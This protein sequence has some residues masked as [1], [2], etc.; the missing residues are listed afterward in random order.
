VQAGIRGLPQAGDSVGVDKGQQAQ[1]CVGVCCRRIG[2][3]LGRHYMPRQRGRGSI[4]RRDRAAHAR[5]M[6][7]SATRAALRVTCGHPSKYR[8]SSLCERRPAPY[9]VGREGVVVRGGEL[10]DDLAQQLRAWRRRTNGPGARQP[11]TDTVARCWRTAA[12][13]DLVGQVS[14]EEGELGHAALG[15]PRAQVGPLVDLAGLGAL[16]VN[17]LPH[18]PSDVQHADEA[19]VRGRGGAAGVE[20][21]V[22]RRHGV[23]LQGGDR[24]PRVAHTPRDASPAVLPHPPSR[25]SRQAQLAGAAGRP[26]RSLSSAQDGAARCQGPSTR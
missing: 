15:L 13:L 19:K 25:R 2:S 26:Y 4:Q 3:E 8:G 9:V 18:L 1:W 24:R 16:A 14:V 11:A 12:D 17:V 22:R 7:L 21:G 10:V 5:V 20:R 23:G 6:S